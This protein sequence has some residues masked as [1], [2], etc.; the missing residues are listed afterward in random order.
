MATLTVGAG[1]QFS[2]LAAAIAASQSGDTI[3]VQ[4]GTY[5]NDWATI[6]HPLTI[7][8]VGGY[9]HFVTNTDISNGK[10]NL[11]V[12]AN[13]TISNCEF[14]GAQVGDL[15]GAG[16]RWEAGNLTVDHCYFH[17]NQEGIL[18]GANPTGVAV[19]T[20]TAFVHNGHDPSDDQE[21]GLYIGTVASL[22]VDNC[23]FSNQNGGQDV[24]SRA[25]TTTITNSIF[26]DPVDGTTNYVIDLPNGG[27]DVVQNNYIQQSGT[28]GNGNIIHFGGEVTNP[29]GSLLVTNNTIA[30]YYANATAVFNQT[31]IDTA[32]VTANNFYHIATV[33]SGNPSSVSGNTTLS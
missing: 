22:T 27:N 7:V 12:D 17:D 9:A 23:Y 1:Q 31:G 19:I 5:T 2:T 11:V 28:P 32:T 14:S 13:L 33:E 24:K 4:A 3:Q 10:A 30:S 6:D 20:N 26:V 29:P 8:G 21:H 18:A 16:I 25:A 15:N